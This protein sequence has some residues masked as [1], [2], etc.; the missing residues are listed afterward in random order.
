MKYL[1]VQTTRSCCAASPPDRKGPCAH[2]PMPTQKVAPL[3]LES[4]TTVPPMATSVDGLPAT[5][6][7]M[8][9]APPGTVDRIH[10]EPSAENHVGVTLR[11]ASS[12]APAAT[13]PIGVARRIVRYSPEKRWTSDHWIPSA[14]AQMDGGGAAGPS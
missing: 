3:A 6:L 11:T 5:S 14:P 12:A 7:T 2:S 13:R 9:L 4:G 1:P 10:V 8:E